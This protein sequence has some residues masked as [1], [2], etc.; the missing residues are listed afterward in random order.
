MNPLATW[1]GLDKQDKYMILTSVVI[2][3]AFWWG[4][5]GRHKYSTK[6]MR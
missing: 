1:H 6:G 4:Y 2:P 3:I 5:F